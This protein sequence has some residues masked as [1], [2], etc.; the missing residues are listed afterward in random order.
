MVI[1]LICDD[2][3]KHKV[4]K[5]TENEVRCRLCGT[6]ITR[7]KSDR[8]PIWIKDK[9]IKGDSTGQ[10]ICYSCAYLKEKICHK[11]G[12]TKFFINNL[13]KSYN[14]MFKHYDENGRWTGKYICR[15]CFYKENI[16]NRNMMY[17]I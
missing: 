17:W 5:K 16:K 15:G 7:K 9:D 12:C 1:K 2:E 13:S 11:C 10:F 6:D 3:I 14:F 8:K 4:Y